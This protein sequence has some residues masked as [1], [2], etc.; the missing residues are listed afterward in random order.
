MTNTLP[1]APDNHRRRRELDETDL[2]K[3]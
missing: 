2:E 1:H 3:R